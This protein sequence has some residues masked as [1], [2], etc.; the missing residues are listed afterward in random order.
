[1]RFWGIAAGVGGVLV[2]SYFYPI[3]YMTNRSDQAVKDEIEEFALIGHAPKY[4]R[5][6]RK[7]TGV[8]MNRSFGEESTEACACVAKKLD[9]RLNDKWGLYVSTQMEESLRSQPTVGKRPHKIYSQQQI[10]RQMR[11]NTSRWQKY[12]EYNKVKMAI[13]STFSI[14]RAN[15]YS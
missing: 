5:T 4:F 10:R 2:S 3:D 6:C 12:N 9:Q 7:W 14:C 1:M 11:G 8:G 15:P 13:N